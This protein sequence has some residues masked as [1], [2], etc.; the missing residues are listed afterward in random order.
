MGPLSRV[1]RGA[2]AA[3]PH[4]APSFRLD[5]SRH[6][7]LALPFLLLGFA[8]LPATAQQPVAVRW[9]GDAP[10]LTETSVSWGVPWPR[11]AVTGS[12]AFAL[13]TAEGARLPLQSWPLAYWPDGSI[14]WT[15]F[16]T[17]AGPD[18][19]QELYLSPATSPAPAPNGA[20]VVVREINGVYEIDTGALKSRILRRGENLAMPRRA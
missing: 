3:T 2:P 18:A 17:V 9:L 11:G 13:T 16:A 14:K 19:P 4:V 12:Q 7:R 1:P 10:P 8:A 15:G 20:G 5:L 6:S